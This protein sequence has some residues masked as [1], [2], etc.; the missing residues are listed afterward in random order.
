M[1]NTS[2]KRV[3]TE[4]EGAVLQYLLPGAGHMHFGNLVSS[5]ESRAVKLLWLLPRQ[6]HPKAH[7]RGSV[8]SG[9]D[10]SSTTTFPSPLLQGEDMCGLVRHRRQK[11]WDLAMGKAIEHP[12]KWKRSHTES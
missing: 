2:V 9:P 10:L 3:K 1:M 6:V 7:G 12:G 5:L 11:A 8:N 4:V